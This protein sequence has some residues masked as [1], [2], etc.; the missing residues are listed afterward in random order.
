LDGPALVE[1]RATSVLVPRGWQLTVDPYGTYVLHH[2][3]QA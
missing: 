1:G 2:S 3:A